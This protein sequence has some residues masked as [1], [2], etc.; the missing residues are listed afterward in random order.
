MTRMSFAFLLLLL[1]PATL[2]AQRPFAET[3]DVVGNMLRVFLPASAWGVT[4]TQN[5]SEGRAQFYRGIGATVAT[6]VVLKAAVDR[7]GPTGL[8]YAF[9]SDN[10]ALSFSAASFAYRRYGWE[11][12]P[13]YALAT[14]SAMTRVYI[15]EQ[16]WDEVLAGAAIG[17]GFSRLFVDSRDNPARDLRVALQTAPE[18]YAIVLTLRW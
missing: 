4:Y 18:E 10:A 9:P 16:R 13:M 6:T 12:W 3:A 2:H 17:V 1:L 11:A 14:F 15:D 8:R 7:D 5:D